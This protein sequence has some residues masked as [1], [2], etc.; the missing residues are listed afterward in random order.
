MIIS[1]YYLSKEQHSDLEEIY[2]MQSEL[3]SLL[4][5]EQQ[6]LQLDNMDEYKYE[7]DNLQEQISLLNGTIL[8]MQDELKERIQEQEIDFS[9]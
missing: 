5:Y 2:K 3:Y 6:M 4:A 7:Y 1:D 8:I 9:F